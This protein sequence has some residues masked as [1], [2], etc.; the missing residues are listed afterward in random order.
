MTPIL[1]TWS[2]RSAPKAESL[3][4]AWA[5]SQGLFQLF[6]AKW[7]VLHKNI[8]LHFNRQYI[9]LKAYDTSAIGINGDAKNF[10]KPIM[11]LLLMFSAMVPAIIFWLIQQFLSKKEDRVTVSYGYI[12][13][14]KSSLAVFNLHSLMIAIV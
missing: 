6:C 1:L 13:R 12:D 3:H 10:A 8:F 5:L 2:L 9:F 4:S 11:M 7:F 14:F